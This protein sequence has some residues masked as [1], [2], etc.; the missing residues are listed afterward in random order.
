MLTII[1]WDVQHG[2]AAYIE[3]PASKHIVQDL[4]TGSYKAGR[5]TFSPLRHLRSQYGVSQLDEVI[6]T[7]PHGDHLDDI[8]NF[9]LLNPRILSRPRHLTDEEIW[10][11]NGNADQ[12]VI[13]KYL[14]INKG[15]GE[16][17]LEG[18]NPL[19]PSNNG[20]VEINVFVPRSC[21]RSNLNNHSLVSV[22]SYENSK[23]IIPG[24]NELPSWQELL[25]RSDFR[26]AIQGSDVLIAPHHGRDA[27][28]CSDIFK[29]FTPRL[30]VISDGRFGD[31][32][33][34]NRYD[35]VT[36]GWTV[37]HRGGPDEQRKCVTTRSDGDILIRIGRDPSDQRPFISVTID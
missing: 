17:V 1:I 7:H 25:E 26:N 10:A 16:P 29:Y 30:T 32:S 20:G 11:G 19:L 28:F 4:G 23:V 9:S 5:M 14:E 6:I 35:K 27:G 34:T 36:S 33:A 37:H 15:Y 21:G 24:D 12:T 3:T 22:I 8:T 31:T 13:E 2:S 18:E